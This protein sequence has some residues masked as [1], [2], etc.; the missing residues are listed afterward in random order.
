MCCVFS[1]FNKSFTPSISKVLHL[2]G[3]CVVSQ[4]GHANISDL[5][6]K[7]HYYVNICVHNTIFVLSFYFINCII[8][9]MEHI[10]K[11]CDL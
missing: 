1:D 6:P 4:V 2:S 9:F 10:F 11:I 3:V 7:E 5:I 8:M